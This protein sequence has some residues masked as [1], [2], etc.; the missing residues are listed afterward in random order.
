MAKTKKQKTLRQL[1][2]KPLLATVLACAG[3]FNMMSAVLAE[4]TAAGTDINNTATATYS[5]GTD[6]FEATSNTVS[7]RVAEIA[8]LT[9]V[10][11]PVL[12]A[13]GGA[14]ESGDD[15]TYIF[16]V[17]N[18]GN[19]PTDVFV[20]DIS[21]LLTTNFTPDA[22]AV[23]VYQA[24]GTT[25]IGTTGIVPAGGG[26]LTD[27]NGTPFTIDPDAGFVVKVTGRPTTGTTAGSAVSVR[28]GDTTNN[29][30]SGPDPTQNQPDN[31]DTDAFANDLR[32]VNPPDSAAG[33]LPGDGSP[34]NGER[35][36]EATASAL[37]ASS[38]RPLALATVLKTSSLST[39]G[40]PAN[41]ADDLITYSL[42]LRVE[43][44]SPSP[45]FQPA[46]LEGTD[47]VTINGATAKRILVSDAIPAGT[48]LASVSTALPAGWT[49]V[50]TTDTTGAGSDP[51]NLAWTT[52][53]PTDLST[54]TRVG[55]IF[56]STIGATGNTITGLNFTVVNDGLATGD[57]VENIA[58][59]FG[60]TVGD[61]S[62]T[63]QVIY[64]E[65]GDA[66]PNN[67]E[68]PTLP[69]DAGAGGDG[70][71]SEYTPGTDDGIADSGNDG[72]D[73]GNN[74]TGT[75]PQGEVN[76]VTLTP[77]DDILNGTQ[78][79]PGAIG[80]TSDND[81]FT[82]KSTP[83]PAAGTDPT[84]L[85]DP[86]PV[87]FNNSLSNPAQ[88]GFISSTTIEPISPSQA[89]AAGGVSGA[90]G[91]NADIPNLTTVT[92][93]ALVNGAPATATY[94]YD[95]ATGLFTT[96]DTPINVGDVTAGTEVDYTVEVNLPPSLDV[97]SDGIADPEGTVQLDEYSIPIIVF[98]DDDPAASP[99]Y[100]G[101]TTNN[102]TIDRLYTGFMSLVKEAQ[103]LDAS[104]AVLEPFTQTP[105]IDAA[106][107]QFI[108]YRLT[109]ENISQA[110]T[111][112]GSVTLTASDFLILENGD[113]TGGNNW[114]NSTTHQQ[115]TTAAPGSRLYFYTDNATASRAPGGPTE[116]D[117]AAG[118][119]IEKY[120][121]L[122]L[123]VAPGATGVFQFRRVVN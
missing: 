35:E 47:V 53:P 37:F 40:T 86:D 74:N 45:L 117:P 21:G 15:L 109:Y 60:Q 30:D 115:N 73:A 2:S 26:T 57:T 55:F 114:A 63:P 43:S 104:G 9:V 29:P 77:G 108:E 12:D 96:P 92:I 70:T 28:L 87:T 105:A 39:A 14:I 34:A 111:G 42:G 61:P 122:V 106:P 71:G 3:V 84:A 69:D 19:A 50:Y 49:A 1:A 18:V 44:T 51:L 24:D 101:E 5:D 41:P 17:T 72:I 95:S 59:V 8:G 123:S 80:P 100:T 54:V 65:S 68:G 90:Y 113:I 16:D 4:G 6:S 56:D 76:V 75:G 31:G 99:G 66:D 78:D 52:V 7:I 93:G 88:A 98:P 121:N 23:K 58:Q 32:T 103:I 91:T 83:T 85:F 11:R 116:A 38:V 107:G 119:P 79:T 118:T 10:A 33:N 64:D 97:N 25:L 89:E 112:S 94:T 20:P 67:F 46:A 27:V 120:E 82:N 110:A 22:D 81:D 62:P 36:S 102:I 13:D 48:D